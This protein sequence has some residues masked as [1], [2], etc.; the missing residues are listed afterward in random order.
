MEYSSTWRS[1]I[2]LK[3]GTEEGGWFPFLPKGCH[4]VGLW[5]EI[6]EEGMFLRQHC[7]VILGDGIKAKFWKDLW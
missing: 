1:V 5:K 4:G 6:S 2:N 7:S 3:Y